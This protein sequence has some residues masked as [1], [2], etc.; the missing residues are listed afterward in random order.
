MAKN[1]AQGTTTKASSAD[2]SDDLLKIINGDS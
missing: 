2:I 1:A